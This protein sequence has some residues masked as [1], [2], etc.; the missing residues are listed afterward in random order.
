M[1]SLFSWFVG[2]DWSSKSH[3]VC[4]LGA[5][6]SVHANRSFP[7]GGAGQAALARWLLDETGAAPGQIAV[8]IETPRG[9][10]VEGLLAAGV[11]VHA[12]GPSQ[13]RGPRR[14]YSPSGAKDD[15]RDARMLARALRADPQLFRRLALEHPLVLQVRERT[16]T[17]NELTRQLTRCQNQIGQQ[18][19]RYFPQ[20]LQIPGLRGQLVEPWFVALWEKTKTPQQ[21]AQLT[22]RVLRNLLKKHGIRRLTAPALRDILQA[23]ALTVAPGT[24]AAAIRALTSLFAQAK[25]T[26]QLVAQAQH[27]LRELLTAFAH[28]EAND[29]RPDD[30]TI[31]LSLPGV[32]LFVASTLF[33]EAYDLLQHRDY[34][35]LR[36]R[37][38]VAPVRIE[39][40]QTGWEVRRLAVQHELREAVYHWARVAS[41]RDPVSKARYQALRARG[42]THGRALRTIGDRLLAVACA[43]L[44]DGTLH[45]PNHTRR[46]AA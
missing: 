29:D 19:W 31:L 1:T 3:Q 38:G 17:L 6:G 32:G 20:L 4:L 7:H 23:P 40:G 44:R 9:P 37:S 26:Q 28:A 36:L 42:Q 34:R 35:A 14:R 39:S 45:D 46:T 43:M 18:L 27:D 13:I 24:V 15:R 30:L 16:R 33:A 10:V 2:I 11:C 41:V 5:D 22:L 8:A 21:A 25:A 12:I